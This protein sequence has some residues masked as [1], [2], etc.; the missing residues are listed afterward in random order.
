MLN[1]ST[2]K[3]CLIEGCAR[4]LYCRGLCEAHYSRQRRYGDPLRVPARRLRPRCTI[5]DCARP[6]WALGCCRLHY[7]RLRSN[8]DPTVTQRV[9]N[10][11]PRRFWSKVDFTE[12]C[13]L[14][15]GSLTRDG[16]GNLG[17]GGVM[18][19]SH[20]WAYE[21]CVGPIPPDMDI[22][23]V[24]FVRNCVNPDHLQPLDHITNVVRRRPRGSVHHA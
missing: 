17:I 11:D 4:P 20:R 23:H 10:N 7:G 1:E 18:K 5:E 9:R 24:C 13:W 6:H 14:W 3:L 19:L 2:P 15:K 21:F 22:D 8:G 12:T 16:Y